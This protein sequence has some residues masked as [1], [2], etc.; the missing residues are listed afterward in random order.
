M[1][2]KKNFSQKLHYYFQV[3]HNT[4]TAEF[5][6]RQH[7]S[8]SGIGIFNFENDEKPAALFKMTFDDVSTCH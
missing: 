5:E 1:G 7:T 6:G 2:H 8:Q 4:D 3:L